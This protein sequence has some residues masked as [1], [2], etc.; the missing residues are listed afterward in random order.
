MA[1]RSS[2]P[3]AYFWLRLSAPSPVLP[4][5]VVL[6]GWKLHSSLRPLSFRPQ[7]PRSLSA[8]PV[9][10]FIAGSNGPLVL[11]EGYR[12][13]L[14]ALAINEEENPTKTVYLPNRRQDPF[15]GVADSL[16]YQLGRPLVRTHS[17]EH[18]LAPF[19]RFARQVTPCYRTN[20]ATKYSLAP[21]VGGLAPI[22]SEAPMLELTK[23]SRAGFL[24]P[25]SLCL[26]PSSEESSP[27]HIETRLS[28]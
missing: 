21:V 2:D 1:C 23:D 10:L 22:G 12:K 18:V 13:C 27:S 16:V 14:T 3:S 28:A 7:L 17:S 25:D 5:P 8:Q 15:A 19:S 11:P 4:L 26:P 20:D 24:R 9:R 6:L